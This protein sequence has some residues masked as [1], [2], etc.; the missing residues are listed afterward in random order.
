MKQNIPV[1]V[2]LALALSMG[3]AFAG[4]DPFLEYNCMGMSAPSS[5][6]SAATAVAAK[7]ASIAVAKTDK[8]SAGSSTARSAQAGAIQLAVLAHG[9]GAAASTA[10]PPPNGSASRER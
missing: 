8:S 5:E 3:S 7:R 1:M 9:V 10:A 2:P 6:E 4:V